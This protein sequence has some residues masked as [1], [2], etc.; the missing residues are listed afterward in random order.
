[1][2]T[3][4]FVSLLGAAL[5]A[6]AQAQTASP[7]TSFAQA[8]V[9][10]PY[11]GLGVTTSRSEIVSGTKYAAKLFGGYDINQTWGM[12]AG[13]TG[14]AAFDSW[15]GH[16]SSGYTQHFN[17]RAKTLYVAAKATMPISQRFALISKLGVAH[18]RGEVAVRNSTWDLFYE[19]KKGRT[20]YY[21]SLGVK[22]LVT[23]AIALTLEVERNGRPS[24][25]HERNE[26]FSLNASYSF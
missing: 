26:A 4:L 23:P 16:P 3:V 6:P 20:G 7:A 2:K 12:E 9:Q 25:A 1:M 19:E 17:A 13:Y 21:S 8:D 11:V 24:V 5:I 22:M 18:T 15:Q 14:Q 10:G